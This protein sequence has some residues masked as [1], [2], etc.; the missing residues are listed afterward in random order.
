[1]SGLLSEQSEGQLTQ[2]SLELAASRAKQYEQIREIAR[3]DHNNF[4]TYI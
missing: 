1:M 2:V 3:L 4:D